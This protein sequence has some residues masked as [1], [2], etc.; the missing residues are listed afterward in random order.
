MTKRFRNRLLAAGAAMLVAAA[1][2]LAATR[3][4][5][6][7]DALVAT[8]AADRAPA[9]SSTADAATVTASLREVDEIYEAD[10]VIEAE[11]A[12]TVSAQIAGIVTA[13]HVDAGDRVSRGQVLVRIDARVSDAQVAAAAAGVEQ[14][15]ARLAQATVE[16]ERTLQLVAQNFV[17]RAALDRTDAELRTA[18]AALQM[19][20]ANATQAATARGFAELR[21]PFDGVVTRRLAEPGELAVP[22][23]PLIEVHDPS[24]LRAVAS[25]PQFVLL[26]LAQV[27]GADVAL[28]QHA[29]PIAATHVTVLPAA[30]PRLLST[31]VRAD[32]PAGVPAGVVPGTAAKVLLRTG[33]ARRLV[34][35]AAAI[36]RRSELTA[37]YVVA[38][39]GTRRLR[40]VRAGD[41]FA[42]RDGEGPLIEVLA[43]LNAGERVL[44][45][46]IGSPPVAVRAG[47]AAP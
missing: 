35:P 20:R 29:S 5:A 15:E 41:M 33:A 16:H 36:V 23:T 44:L 3:F 7:S 24:A 6:R 25:V 21:A 14:A 4:P 39:D 42:G 28:P 40:Q 37:V 22:G 9:G 12:A 46:P 45:A 13:F 10:A 43:G 34:V 8:H 11:R 38:D 26:R 32:L 47:N 30:D 18:R 27:R 31:Q 17:S 2:A 1:A 19:A